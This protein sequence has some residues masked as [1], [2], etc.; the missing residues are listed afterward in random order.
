MKNIVVFFFPVVSVNGMGNIALPALG[1]FE[2]L[3]VVTHAHTHTH[4]HLTWELGKGFTI[5]RPGGE[6]CTISVMGSCGCAC[7]LLVCLFE[8]LALALYGIYPERT[9][10]DPRCVIGYT[11][12]T[13]T[14]P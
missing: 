2:M 11:V 13:T 6:L 5:K 12:S 8:S 10:D 1:D 3:S 4:T 14:T 9:M 7:Y